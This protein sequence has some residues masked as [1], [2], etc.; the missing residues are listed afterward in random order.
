MHNPQS[1]MKLASGLA[2]LP[3]M[4][5]REPALGLGTDGFASNNDLSLWEEIVTAAK[6]HKLI[7]S[8]KLVSAQEA[9]EMATI[10]GA[11]AL[12]LHDQIGSPEVGKRADLARLDR[13]SIN[14]I[15]VSSTDSALV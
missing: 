7:C 15:P 10:R 11:R 2:P 3:A 9:F 4:L 6:L 14:Q 5:K 1:T 13:E 8:P 12:H